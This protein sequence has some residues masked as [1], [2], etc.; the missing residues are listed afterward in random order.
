MTLSQTEQD[1]SCWTPTTPRQNGETASLPYLKCF[2]MFQY[3][4][5]IF[6]TVMLLTHDNLGTITTPRYSPTELLPCQLLLVCVGNIPKHSNLSPST[7]KWLN[8]KVF[9]PFIEFV[10]ITL[11]VC[12]HNYCN[13]GKWNHQKVHDADSLMWTLFPWTYPSLAFFLDVV[14]ENAPQLLSILEL[15]PPPHALSSLNTR[16]YIPEGPVNLK[17]LK[18]SLTHFSTFNCSSK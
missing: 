4:K 12:S 17:T 1:S 9:R 18:L 11:S 3:D 15:F 5:W 16:G 10:R 8:P 6:M 13:I 2:Y 14:R 7:P